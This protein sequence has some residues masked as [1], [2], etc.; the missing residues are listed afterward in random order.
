MVEF[1]FNKTVSCIEHV[2]VH[3]S[4]PPKSEVTVETLNLL[5]K[6]NAL[7][8]CIFGTFFTIILS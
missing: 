2:C 5:N 6:K 1:V 7:V 4:L 8:L 3:S